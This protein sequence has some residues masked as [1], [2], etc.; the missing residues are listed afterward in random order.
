MK[1]TC[2]VSSIGMMLQLDL[3]LAAKFQAREAPEQ[4]Y[5]AWITGVEW[6]STGFASAITISD[7]IRRL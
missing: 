2:K 6:G 1:L 3:A 4:I 5:Q 7:S